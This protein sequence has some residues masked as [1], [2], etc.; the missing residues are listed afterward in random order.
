[1]PRPAARPGQR[2]TRTL[3]LR[4][5][6]AS[7][8]RRLRIPLR[9]LVPRRR[10]RTALP[11]ARPQSASPRRRLLRTPRQ[12]RPRPPALPLLPLPPMPRRQPRPAALT[13]RKLRRT[14]LLPPPAPRRRPVTPAPHQRRR[15]I[16]ATLPAPA[17]QRL[18]L[19][20]RPL[21]PAPAAKAT[22]APTAN[23]GNTTSARTPATPAAQQ[24]PPANSN[25]MVWVNTDS[26]VYHKPGTRYYGKTKQGK[27]MSEADAQKAGYRAA[28]KN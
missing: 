21:L 28:E 7:L 19:Q 8:R 26:G 14:Q 16:A 27:Y 5:Q 23:S 18:R 2:R 1:M 4:P 3:R 15:A 17:P 22:P 6:S 20:R 13:N 25:G 10:Q 11:R 9:R 24:T 12:P